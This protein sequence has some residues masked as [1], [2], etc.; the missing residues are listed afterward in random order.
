MRHGARVLVLLALGL[1]Y[2]SL[3]CDRLQSLVRRAKPVAGN[4][5]TGQPGGSLFEG[6]RAVVALRALRAAAG[7]PERRVRGPVPGPSIVVRLHVSGTRRDARVR[8]DRNG[9]I[10]EL[11]LN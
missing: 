4:A 7:G 9:K 10:L 2:G 6:E 5:S 8:A 3:G 1:S 11:A